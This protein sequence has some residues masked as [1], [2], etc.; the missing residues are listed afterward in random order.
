MILGLLIAMVALGWA[1]M[2]WRRRGLGQAL[3]ALAAGLFLAVGCGFVPAWLLQ[4]LQAGYE[5]KPSHA[6]GPRNAIVVLG[7]AMEK[8]PSTGSVEPV[9]SSYA[10]LVEAAGLQREC[11]RTG[12]QCKI[13]LSGGDT[14]HTGTSEAMV[15]RNALLALGLAGDDVLIEPYSTGTWQHARFTSDVLRHFCADHVVLVSS[16]LQLRRSQLYLTHFGV[17]ATQ[18]RAGYQCAV[19]SLLPR[20]HNFV[21]ADAALHEYLQMAHYRLRIALGDM[22]PPPARLAAG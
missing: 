3:H 5:A 21:L 15:Y 1:C 7:N 6:W 12:G 19:K 8:I 13:V 17:E 2:A 11:S 14:A 20:P 10:R 22:G 16:G 18:V 9:L 4:D